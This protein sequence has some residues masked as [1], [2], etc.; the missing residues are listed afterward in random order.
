ME[1]KRH[2]SHTYMGRLCEVDDLINK[3]II[4][5]EQAFY[6]RV[7][8]SVEEAKLSYEDYKKVILCQKSNTT[9]NNTV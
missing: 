7:L 8:A 6:L 3:K 1:V 5:P 4:T 2:F 9:N